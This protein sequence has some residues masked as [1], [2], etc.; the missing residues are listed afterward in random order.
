MVHGAGP[1]PQSL[2]EDAVLRTMLEHHLHTDADAQHRASASKSPSDQYI[3]AYPTDAIHAGR[4]RAHARD[5]QTIGGHGGVEVGGDGDLCSYALQ[6]A[7]RRT[8]VA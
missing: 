5:D 1:L 3:P 8:D 7:L 4:E 6:S 2:G